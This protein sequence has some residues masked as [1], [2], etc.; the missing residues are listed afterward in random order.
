[1]TI[2]SL[3]SKLRPKS[4]IMF[5]KLYVQPDAFKIFRST[6]VISV[7][8][9]FGEKMVVIGYKLQLANHVEDVDLDPYQ[10]QDLSLKLNSAAIFCPSQYQ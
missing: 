6:D 4:L 5:I 2:L 8:P 3:L 9:V 1:M 7:D 10:A